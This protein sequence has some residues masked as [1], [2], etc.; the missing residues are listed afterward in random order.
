M[1]VLVLIFDPPIPGD[2]SGFHRLG[3][4]LSGSSASRSDYPDRDRAV[5]GGF[6]L[7]LLRSR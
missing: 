4:E 3:P 2:E 6:R 5:R 1:A 7:R